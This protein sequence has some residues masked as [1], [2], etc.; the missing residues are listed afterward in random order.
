M[1]RSSGFSEGE[2]KQNQ[3]TLRNVM[4][5]QTIREDSDFNLFNGRTL[6]DSFD[7]PEGL[8][9]VLFFKLISF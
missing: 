5:F 1:L 6:P 2:I 4:K 7:I 9:F 3:Q 8:L